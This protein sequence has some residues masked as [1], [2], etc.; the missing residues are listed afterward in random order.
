IFPLSTILRTVIIALAL[1]CPFHLFG[2]GKAVQVSSS[3]REIIIDYYPSRYNP[4]SVSVNS[5]SFFY[6]PESELTSKAGEPGLPTESFLI[7]IPSSGNVKI[8]MI[9]E[10]LSEPGAGRI[11]AVPTLS[12][13]SDSLHRIERKFTESA[14]SGSRSIE[15]VRV[16]EAFW[17]R[18]QRISPISV[19]PISFNPSNQTFRNRGRMRFKVSF[20]GPSDSP[21]LAPPE[22]P[23]TEE[24][25]KS[26][27]LNYEQARPWRSPAASSAQT[28][29]DSTGTWFT[30][31]QEFVKIPIA[32][33]GMYRLFF[34]DL[35]SAGTVPSSL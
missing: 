12:V 13:S 2:Q 28:A 30:P 24:L 26:I 8:E 33:D 34:S 21:H 6:F 35:V 22:T 18:Y 32:R 10:Q 7:G 11:A 16:D 14:S 3:D 31:G 9:E 25:Y 27:L 29:L 4:Q 1:F 17:W 23:R 19:R 20:T 15:A 5:Q